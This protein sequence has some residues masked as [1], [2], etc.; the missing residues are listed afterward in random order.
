MK[1]GILIFT[2]KFLTNNPGILKKNKYFYLYSIITGIII[3]LIFLQPDFGSAIVLLLSVMSLMFIGEFKLKN[4]I[5]GGTFLIMSLIGLIM[6]A[7]YRME[8]ITSFLDPWSDPL[9][10]GFQ[11]IQSLYAIAPASLFGYGLFNSKQKFFFLPEPYNEVS[12][13]TGRSK[14]KVA[15]LSQK[16]HIH[17]NF[18]YCKYKRGVGILGRKRT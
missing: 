16:C 9:G 1:L 10:S 17:P 13:S 14:R 12:G 5:I 11:I 15:L 7:P 6:I 2:S 3:G 4:L 8:R 18:K